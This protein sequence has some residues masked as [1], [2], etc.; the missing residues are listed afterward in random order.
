MAPHS[1]SGTGR[2]W[3]GE[4]A[5]PGQPW[6]GTA[7][8][9]PQFDGWFPKCPSLSGRVAAI[10]TS[11]SAGQER[12]FFGLS[13]ELSRCHFSF[14]SSGCSAGQSVPKA[15]AAEREGL[16]LPGR[17]TGIS[18]G[19]YGAVLCMLGMLTDPLLAETEEML[20][21]HVPR[22]APASFLLSEVGLADTSTQRVA[23]GMASNPDGRGWAPCCSELLIRDIHACMWLGIQ[24]A[25]ILDPARRHSCCS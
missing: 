6:V 13:P 11:S 7:H 17:G 21:H 18:C 5:G 3:P 22:R 8:P 20:L 12:A 14:P 4:G 25:L 24:G 9:W 15:K 10:Y 1:C 16:P 19:L 2:G 23:L